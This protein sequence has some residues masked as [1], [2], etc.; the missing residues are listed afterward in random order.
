M[1]PRTA[2]EHLYRL[3][4]GFPIVSVTG[5]RQSGKTTLARAA[6]PHLPYVNLE[7][8]AEL[9]LAED[10]P[11]GF[12][13]HY[14]DGVILDEI[15]RCPLLFSY[16][17]AE[18]D[19]D[20]RMGRFVITGSQQFG[21]NARI[22]QSLAGRV[23]ALT[24]LPFSIGELTTVERCPDAPDDLLW[25]GLYPPIYDR[26]VDPTTWYDNY[27]QTY[28]ERD[29]RDLSAVQDLSLFRRFLMLCAGRTGQLVN[30]ASLASDAGVDPK[31]ARSWLSLLATSFII[32]LVVPHHRNLNKR[33]VKSP[34]L[35]FLD[36]GLAAS[37]IGVT[38]VTQIAAHPLRGPLFETLIFTELLKAR[39][40]RGQNPRITFWRDNH[41]HEVDF[42]I[43]GEHQLHG[44]EVK[45]GATVVP[46]SL[47]WLRY[48]ADLATELTCQLSL[49]H[50]GDQQGESHGIRLVRWPE[51][52]SIL[53]DPS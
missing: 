22:S 40:H 17:Q 35:Y 1:I 4:R 53:I 13:G 32:Q 27:V 9:A 6:F 42:L 50:G 2:T 52:E 26:D 36:P 21:M 11:L 15:Q 39:V 38:D 5:P 37:L 41:G 16:L 46:G 10:D 29:L 33:L 45:S 51:V 31:T 7:R 48:F 49:V 24:L 44:V 19:E 8:P 23:G 47:K 43:E 3:T 25:Q 34:K 28:L 30:Y 14:P 20:G 18:V 12:L